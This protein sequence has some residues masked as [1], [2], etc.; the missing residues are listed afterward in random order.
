MRAIA[1]VHDRIGGDTGMGHLVGDMVRTALDGG[2]EVTLL[3]AEVEADLRAG[4][5]VIEVPAAA[6]RDLAWQRE[7]TSAALA[8]APAD[9]LVHGHLAPLAGRADLMTCHHL[10]RAAADHGVPVA[11]EVVAFDD[12]CYARSG[13][14]TFVSPFLRDECARLYGRSG[15]VIGPVAPPWDPVERAPGRRIVVGYAGG[16]DV[17]KGVDAVR[18]LAAEEDIELVLAGPHAERIEAAGARVAGWVDVREFAAT[19][20]V[21]VAPSLFDALAVVVLEALS[22]GTPAVVGPAVGVA[23]NLAR[24]A[25]GIVWDGTG[26]LADAVRAAAGIERGRCER[27]LAEYSADAQR[28]ALLAAYERV[29]SLLRP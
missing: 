24:H 13:E 16:D 18:A 21:L 1:M 8:A 26:S 27:F 19:V 4:C 5:R 22:R 14:L 12:E 11:Q 29:G 3:A 2:C 7:W 25:A 17:R 6:R 10:A 20:D 23:D 9:H 28:E 15:P